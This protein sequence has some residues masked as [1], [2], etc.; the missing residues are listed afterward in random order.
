LSDLQKKSL[1]KED[2]VENGKED[3][4]RKQAGQSKDAVNS[5]ASSAADLKPNVNAN[6]NAKPNAKPNANANANVAPS[7]AAKGSDGETNAAKTE[8]ELNA[9]K[10]LAFKQRQQQ[11]NM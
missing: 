6:V 10:I 9:E 3:T 5:S 8:R 2:S 1:N 4:K 7:D 11:Q